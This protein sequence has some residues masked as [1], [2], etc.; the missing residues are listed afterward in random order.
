MI[1]VSDRPKNRFRIIAGEWRGRR[2]AFPEG[3]DIRPSPDRVRET[4]FNWLT[5]VIEGALCLDLFAG[6]GALGL[7]ALSRG[8][9]QVLFVDKDPFVTAMIGKHLETVRCPRGRVICRNAMAFLSTPPEN[10]FDVIFLD[11]PFRQELISGALQKLTTENWVRDG[12][13][14]YLECEADLQLDLPSG[15]QLIRSGRAGKVQFHLAGPV[16]DQKG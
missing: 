3:T 7:E 4:L 8:A 10:L 16:I 1:D 14:V 15:W 9:A 5:P 11:P 2:F 12:G 6:S 13:L